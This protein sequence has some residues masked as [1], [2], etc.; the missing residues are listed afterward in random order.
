MLNYKRGWDGKKRG[1]NSQ[2]SSW[3]PVI[4]TLPN[5]KEMN[6]KTYINEIDIS[7]IQKG[8]RVEIGI[9]AFP[10]KHFTGSIIDIANMGE[11][12]ANSNAKVFEV[13]I[14]VNEFDSILRPSMTT[15]NTIITDVID[16]V[17]YIPIECIQNNDSMSYVITSNEKKQIISG[18]YNE[19]E[20]IIKAGL[21]KDEMIY[22]IPPED[23]EDYDLVLL[24][25]TIIKKYTV[26]PQIDTITNEDKNGM[27]SMPEQFKNMSR[28]DIQ[29]MIKN[30][31]RLGKKSE[32]G[33]RQ[34][35]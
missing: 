2:I 5:L 26:V 1:V 25:S 9:D 23:C 7:K 27:E 33:K 10:D 28:K 11:Q 21:V 34:K 24:D 35:K 8:Q 6:S 18:K 17:L 13:M 12:M 3:D 22:L 31:G 29:K 15:K 16:S 4:A 19:N 20:I 32:K 14:K 30:K